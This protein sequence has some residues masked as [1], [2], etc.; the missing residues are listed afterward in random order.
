MKVDDYTT[1][2]ANADFRG[3][4]IPGP[5][6]KTS[7]PRRSTLWQK[8]LNQMTPYATAGE[9][10]KRSAKSKEAAL[11]AIFL[12]TF[13]FFWKI[14][15]FFKAFGHH[16]RTENIHCNFFFPFWAH[17]A[18]CHEYDGWRKLSW[19]HIHVHKKVKSD[20]TMSDIKFTTLPARKKFNLTPIF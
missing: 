2:C 11:F 6:F 4:W 18:F 5:M 17:L 16:T 12:N 1:F 10:R 7:L 13:F 14:L 20:V 3:L 15:I 19:A 9:N 8:Y